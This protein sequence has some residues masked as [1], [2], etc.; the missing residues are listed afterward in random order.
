MDE[1]YPLLEEAD[2]IVF[3]SPIYFSNVSARIKNLMD[4][5]NPY[6]FNGK[7]KGKYM[8]VVGVGQS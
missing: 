8:V 4:R 2:V 1:I 6:F 3:G 7:L 5:C